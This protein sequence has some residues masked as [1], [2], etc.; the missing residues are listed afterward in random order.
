MTVTLWINV[1]ATPSFHS[2]SNWARHLPSRIRRTTGREREKER[3]REGER[4]R[5]TTT[6]SRDC[7]VRF[8]LY[9][10]RVRDDSTLVA[11]VTSHP[12]KDKSAVDIGRRIDRTQGMASLMAH[13]QS[14]LRGTLILID[15]PCRFPYKLRTVGRKSVKWGNRN[16][17]YDPLE[18]IALEIH[19]TRP[20]F[21]RN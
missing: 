12:R 1:R 4:R 16:N 20:S 6:R 11:T 13:D 14:C 18:W 15:E 5:G 2:P 17:L 8:G 10:S 19:E 7:G 21:V 3:E 9:W